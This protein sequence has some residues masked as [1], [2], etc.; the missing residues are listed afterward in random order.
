[1]RV[2]NKHKHNHFN[3]L[4]VGYLLGQLPGRMRVVSIICR[5]WK[6]GRASGS[7]WIWARQ[8]IEKWMCCINTIA[9]SIAYREANVL[10]MASSSRPSSRALLIRLFLKLLMY[11]FSL[12]IIILIVVNYGLNVCTYQSENLTLIFL[13]A[14][15][16]PLLLS[17]WWS[18]HDSVPRWSKSLC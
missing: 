6:I 5:S 17:G 10:R 13:Y 11:R 9:N 3:E 7:W 1:M 16:G 15:S 14:N 2:P 18:P 4:V 8:L 12:H